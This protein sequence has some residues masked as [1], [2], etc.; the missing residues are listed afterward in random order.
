MIFSHF[1]K[2]GSLV[3]AQLNTVRTSRRKR[4]PQSAKI[5]E[6]PPRKSAHALAWQLETLLTREAVQLRAMPETRAQE[7]PKL[8]GW[9]RKEELGHLID[10]AVNNHVRFVAAS[11]QE[12]YEGPSYDQDGWVRAHGYHDM[13]MATLVD[14]WE[15]HNTLL[16]AAIQGIPEDKL[17]VRCRIGGGEAVTLGFIVEDYLIHM[18]HHLDHL[19]GREKITR[20]PPLA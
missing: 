20:Y 16:T 6:M 13:P 5:R 1:P 11:L 4:E 2:R 3:F 9:S 12:H 7:K 18:Q 10:S 14:L 8:E 17:A 19:L 15:A